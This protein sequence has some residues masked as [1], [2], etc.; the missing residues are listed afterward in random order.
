MADKTTIGI[1]K[2]TMREL[3]RRAIDKDMSYVE[4]LES[5]LQK[6]FKEQD[7]NGTNRNKKKLR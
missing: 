1:D 2:E 4:Y 7:G 5:V 3:K 6:H